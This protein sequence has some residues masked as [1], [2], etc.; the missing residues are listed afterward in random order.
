MKKLIEKLRK[1]EPISDKEL[2]VMIPWYK[3]AHELIEPFGERLHL[4]WKEVYMDYL[5]LVD[6]KKAR[7][8][9]K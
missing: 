5:R 2:E 1:G 8:S 9:H 7:E 3:S 4:A 6:M